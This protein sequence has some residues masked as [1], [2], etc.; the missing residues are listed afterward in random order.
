MKNN[1]FLIILVSLFLVFSLVACSKNTSN[2]NGTTNNNTNASTNNNTNSNNN[3]A[4]APTQATSA[5]TTV[6]P[7]TLPEG[8]Y[9]MEIP[10]L[11]DATNVCCNWWGIGEDSY[12]MYEFKVEPK[13]GFKNGNV[14]Q[15]RW[16]E[17]GGHRYAV[18]AIDMKPSPNSVNPD[19]FSNLT[20]ISFD[21]TCELDLTDPEDEDLAILFQNDLKVQFVF[22]GYSEATGSPNTIFLTLEKHIELEECYTPKTVFVE[23][24]EEETEI[25]SEAVATALIEADGATIE[26]LETGALKPVTDPA[27]FSWFQIGFFNGHSLAGNDDIIFDI[28]FKVGNIN[29]YN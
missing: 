8:Q 3:S 11:E 9:V 13:E 19:C 24:T 22:K 18:Y 26:D 6:K 28:G 20:K 17:N 12:G 21:Y 10:N 2:T 27:Y 4:V 5:T 16:K 15:G 25:L 7:T 29:F 1:K 14:L 23:L